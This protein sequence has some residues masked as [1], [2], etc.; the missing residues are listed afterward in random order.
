MGVEI[1]GLVPHSDKR[2][3]DEWR[4]KDGA[5][6]LWM[7]GDKRQTFAYHDTIC[8]VMIDPICYVMIDTICYMSMNI[9][10]LVITDY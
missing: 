6:G 4:E 9:S 2:V 8:Y 10:Q 1:Y 3:T 5:R 7:K